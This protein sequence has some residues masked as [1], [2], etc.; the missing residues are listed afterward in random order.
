MRSYDADAL[1]F[2]LMYGK[3]DQGLTNNW[4]AE[5][6]RCHDAQIMSL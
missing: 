6:L 3:S 5:D 4:V 2:Q 1:I